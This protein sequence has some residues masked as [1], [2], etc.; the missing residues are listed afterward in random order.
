MYKF[1]MQN[2]TAAKCKPPWC[3]CL[4]T[5]DPNCYDEARGERETQDLCQCKRCYNQMEATADNN[6]QRVYSSTHFLDYRDPCFPYIGTK[7]ANQQEFQRRFQEYKAKRDAEDALKEPRITPAIPEPEDRVD[8]NCMC[9]YDELPPPRYKTAWKA[10][11]SWWRNPT[12][13]CRKNM[14]KKYIWT[15][16]YR[17]ANKDG[18]ALPLAKR[19]IPYSS[20][21]CNANPIQNMA[22]LADKTLVPIGS[23]T[24]EKWDR[25][26]VRLMAG[27]C[28][29][30]YNRPDLCHDAYFQEH[31]LCRAK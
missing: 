31:R 2:F 29:T 22:E 26:Q 19:D 24:F 9:I 15:T 30:M 7:L 1:C 10:D 20:K 13:D 21:E 12:D 25:P 28:D 14:V 3:R 6:R 18:A 16:T 17:E 8:P 4:A 27:R 23:P 5:G 11:E